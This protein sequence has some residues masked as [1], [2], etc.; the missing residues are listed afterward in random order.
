MESLQYAKGEKNKKKTKKKKKQIHASF[1]EQ[2]QSL[3]KATEKCT[4]AY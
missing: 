2:N 1:E 3:Q 4:P